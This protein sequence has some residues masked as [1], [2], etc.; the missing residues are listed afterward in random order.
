MTKLTIH[1]IKAEK[2]DIPVKY[3]PPNPAKKENKDIVKT[4]NTP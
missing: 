2:I 1:I 3:D 4:V